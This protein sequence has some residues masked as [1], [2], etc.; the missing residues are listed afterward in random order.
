[1]TNQ[2][3]TPDWRDD[4]IWYTHEPLITKAFKNFLK[5]ALLP[6]VQTETAGMEHLP[7]TGGCVVACNHIS[8]LDPMFVGMYLPRYPHYMAKHN[9]YKA[10][11]M[12]WFFRTAASFPVHRGEKDEWALRQAGRVLEAGEVLFMF[13]EGTRSKDNAKLQHGK[14][15]AMKLAIDYQVPI[16]PMALMGSH[17][18]KPA[19]RNRNRVTMQLGEPLDIKGIAGTPPYSAEVLQ[20]LTEV[21]MRQIA[22]MLPVKNRGVYENE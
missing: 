1:M 9:L 6:I 13:P 2:P 12:R 17:A 11:P 4:Y 10:G 19:L 14:V 21:L 18:I 20:Q 7:K 5:V 15:G 22:A 8:N 3:T 16:L